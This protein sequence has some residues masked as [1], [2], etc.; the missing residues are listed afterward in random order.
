MI[1]KSAYYTAGEL[2]CPVIEFYESGAVRLVQSYRNNRKNGIAKEY[3]ENGRLKAEI[4]YRRGDAIASIQYDESG[5]IIRRTEEKKDFDF[6]EHIP[7]L[8]PLLEWAR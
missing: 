7:Q 6:L 5:K 4:L 3:F 1:Q 2:Q 8:E